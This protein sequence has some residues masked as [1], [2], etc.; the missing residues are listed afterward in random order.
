MEKILVY[1]LFGSLAVSDEDGEILHANIEKALSGDSKVIVDFNNV[2]VVLTQFLNSAIAT[3]YEKHDSDELKQRLVI[4]G[5]KSTDSLRKVI[6]R[7]KTFYADE[8]KVA[9]FIDK[10]QIYG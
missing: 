5:L 7:A 4:T 9:E 10:E 2:E 3:L 6:A 1:E 8:K